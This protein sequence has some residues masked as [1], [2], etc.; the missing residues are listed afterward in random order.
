[1][2][3]DRQLQVEELDVLE[4]I[5]GHEFLRSVGNHCYE[6]R[7][8]HVRM[9]LHL[10]VDYPSCSPPILELHD[11]SLPCFSSTEALSEELVSMFTPGDVV[12][13]DW[14]ENIKDKCDQ[15]ASKETK[16]E[17][18]IVG[19]SSAP[20]S[21]FTNQPKVE[22]TE[23]EAAMELVA[24]KIITGEALLER[25]STFQAHIASINS[26]IEAKAMVEVL[27]QSSNKIRSASHNMMA[28]RIEIKDGIFAQDCDDDGEAAAGGRL[29]HLLQI[30]DCRNVVVVVSRWFGGI[31][32]GPS[33]F[34][35]I[36]NCARDLLEKTGFI[37]SNSS[38]NGG[39][40]KK[41]SGSGR[42][43]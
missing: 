11:S 6:I 7:F 25:K 43:R 21:P 42:N 10:P 39:G 35:H 5:Y 26:P 19:A 36:N 30:A 8:A 31:L 32:L 16:E 38:N 1:M 2:G 17:E 15:A 13:F 34:T 27:L 41:G 18:E 33:R 14:V 22:L 23:L 24:P 29:L 12:L 9:V 37:V 4:S 20:P 40:K 3:D 28:Y